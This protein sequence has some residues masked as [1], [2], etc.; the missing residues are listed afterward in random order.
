MFYN[1]RKAGDFLRKNGFHILDRIFVRREKD[2]ERAFS[3]IGFPAVMK[4]SGKKIV[5][6]KKIGGV[7]L[8]IKNYGDGLLAFK[9]LKKIK[10]FEE[11]IIQPV[12]MGDEF[13]L[14]IKKAPEFGHI[15]LFG[16]GGSNVEK[17]KDVS[18]R[19]YPLAKK[20][21]KEMIEETKIS[22]KIS[23]SEKKFLVKSILKLN[24]LIKRHSSIK[25][26]DINPMKG[27]FVVDSRAVF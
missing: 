24:S 23:R 11:A 16:N 19:V 15:I 27:N 12:V 2:L 26:L 4:I 6:K 8:G 13:I 20:D 3:K 22:K 5:H 17:N 14:G 21:A 25:E 7:I 9:K 1:E 10:G 18:F